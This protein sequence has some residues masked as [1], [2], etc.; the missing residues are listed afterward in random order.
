MKD[1]TVVPKILQL[2][3]FLVNGIG[4]MIEIN[5]ICNICIFKKLNAASNKSGARA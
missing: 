3:S 2:H 1:I 4:E 5:P